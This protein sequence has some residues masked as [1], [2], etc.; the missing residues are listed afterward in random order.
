MIIDW[1]GGSVKMV[2]VCQ[3][4]SIFRSLHLGV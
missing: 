3:S 2:A 1:Q 4:H